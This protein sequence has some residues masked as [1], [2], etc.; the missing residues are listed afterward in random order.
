MDNF[1][2]V[3]KLRIK[4]QVS[5]EEAKAALEANDW[6]LLDAL[7][8]LESRGKTHT[9]EKAYYTTKQEPLHSTEKDYKKDKS[10]S[11]GG[12]V[13]S[14]FS[15]LIDASN[16]TMFQFFYRGKNLFELPITAMVFLVIMTF[17]TII[18]ALIIAMFFGIRYKLD[19]G[20][21]NVEKA[22]RWLD[23]AAD[24]VSRHDNDD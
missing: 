4:T 9:A 8:Y 22:N 1:E 6:D 13:L 19:S 16:R 3:E 5:Y 17:P 12:R 18:F 20:G 7:I 24:T 14:S 21:G 10:S 23:K 11:Y 15:E 2:M